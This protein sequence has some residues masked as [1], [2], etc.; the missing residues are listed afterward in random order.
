MST[1][2]EEKNIAIST[3]GIWLNSHFLHWWMLPSLHVHESW[4]P[5]LVADAALPLAGSDGAI[6]H[7]LHQHWSSQLLERLAVDSA[8]LT[9]LTAHPALPV[10]IASSTLLH[11][12]LQHAGMLMSSPQLR[13]CIDRSSRMQV[14]QALGEHALDWAVRTA[15]QLHAGLSAITQ[16]QWH[17]MA[18]GESMHWL[19]AQLLLS[20]LEGAPAVLRE[21]LQW[22]L[23]MQWLSLAKPTANWPTPADAAVI[24]LQLMNTLDSAWLSSLPK[25]R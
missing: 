20:A 12:W 18:L 17:G 13:R 23:P 21:R 7:A 22:Q 16:L 19:G 8:Q 15:P 10:C 14:Q 25:T 24:S 9:A 2:V 11:R 3:D 4:L 6:H 5:H 1:L